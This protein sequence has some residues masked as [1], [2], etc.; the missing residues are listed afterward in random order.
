M[1]AHLLEDEY[2]GCDVD[3]DVE[4]PGHYV[5]G[6][7]DGCWNEFDAD[8]RLVAMCKSE[9]HD[10]DAH[11]GVPSPRIEGGRTVD[12]FRPLPPFKAREFD[13]Y[14]DRSEWFVPPPAEQFPLLV[15]MLARLRT[16]AAKRIPDPFGLDYTEDD[17]LA[18]CEHIT[19]VADLT[20]LAIELGWEDAVREASE[21]LWVRV[22][23]E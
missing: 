8:Q 6:F 21:A 19:E 2:R 3:V 7:P 5:L 17:Y 13:E 20:R 1:T 16:D 9:H 12:G 11:V 23:C 22:I 4:E 14:S 15:A 18:G 10:P